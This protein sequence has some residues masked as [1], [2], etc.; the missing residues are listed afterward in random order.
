MKPKSLTEAVKSYDFSIPIHLI[1]IET[2][3]RDEEERKKEEK[4]KKLLLDNNYKFI[5][6]CYHNEIYILNSSYL[7]KK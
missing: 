2:L 1:L 3:H 4:C 5:T 7:L 6:K